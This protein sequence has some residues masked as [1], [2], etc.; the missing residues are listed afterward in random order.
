MMLRLHD[1]L[2]SGNGFKVR[3]LL[4][5]LGL[6]FERIEYD[7]DR[8][9]TRT[10]EFLAKNPNGRVPVLE[11]EDGSF[12]AESNAILWYLAEATPLLPEEGERRQR[13]EVLQWM[14]F[15]QYSHEP[16]IATVRFWLTHKTPPPPSSS[17]RYRPSARRGRRRWRS[18][19][20]IWRLAGSSSASATPSRTSRFTPTHTSPL[21]AGSTSLPIPP[22]GA[23]WSGSR[24]SPGTF[25]SPGGERLKARVRRRT[26]IAP[27]DRA[28][29]AV[30]GLFER[31]PG[32]AAGGLL[33]ALD[34]KRQTRSG[35]ALLP[36]ATVG[37]SGAGAGPRRAVPVAGAHA[38]RV[39]VVRA[40][41]APR[42]AHAIGPARAVGV[43]AAGRAGPT[44]VV[45]ACQRRSAP[46]A[47]RRDR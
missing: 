4:T 20:A 25:R 10:P 8:R 23:G 42:E 24:S 29:D 33:D 30:G 2:S 11:F 45:W 31:A 26:G 35:I 46:E 32:G 1:S 17:C 36:G 38:D 39:G 5:Q 21:K 9:A 7:I 14:F 16:N 43:G 44:A 27:A 22:F 40:R 18:W 28:A 37:T 15:E 41:T 6:P 13:A 12:L 19:S 47:E 34:R 3:L